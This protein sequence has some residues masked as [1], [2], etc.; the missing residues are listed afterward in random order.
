MRGGQQSRLLVKTD[1]L[2]RAAR[3]ARQFANFHHALPLTS[4]LNRLTFLCLQGVDFASIESESAMD[5]PPHSHIRT[6]IN[7]QQM[8]C[9]TEEALLRKKL[10]RLASVSQMEFNLMQRVL[11]VAHAPDA[12]QSV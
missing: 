11:T 12:L 4:C 8:D 9:P 5:H 1:G 10:M 6:S 3:R 2:R 7:I